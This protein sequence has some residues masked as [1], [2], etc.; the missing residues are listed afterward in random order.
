MD[1]DFSKEAVLGRMLSSAEEL[2][3][4]KY[5]DNLD[6]VVRLLMESFAAE[7]FKVQ[8]NIHASNGR[9]VEHLAEV[10][11]P[12]K[13]T[14]AVPAHGVMHAGCTQITRVVNKNTSY[15]IAGGTV[16]DQKFLFTPIDNV[17]LYHAEVTDVIASH[18]ACSVDSC[19]YKSVITVPKAGSIPQNHMWLGISVSRQ[20]HDI[21]GLSFFIDWP[22]LG[23]KN[24][25][26]RAMSIAKWTVSGTIQLQMYKGL[27][28]VV[29]DRDKTENS[30]E[31]PEVHELVVNDIKNSYQNQFFT[32][33]NSSLKLQENTQKYPTVFEN[34]FSEQ[35]LTQFFTE[36]KLWI[37]IELP[38]YL[39][40][41]ILNHMLV[42]TNAFPIINR[43]LKQATTNSYAIPLVCESTERIVSVKEVYGTVNGAYKPIEL[44][45]AQHSSNT[46]TFKKA[47]LERFDLRDAYELVKYLEL[48]LKNEVQAFV[49][50]NNKEDSQELTR[51][52]NEV[53]SKTKKVSNSEY[54]ALQ[55]VMLEKEIPDEVVTA[56]FWVTRCEEANQIRMG[57]LSQDVS[58]SS[59]VGC[60]LLTHTIGG[61]D[62]QSETERIRAYQY[63]LLTKEQIVSAQDIKS[64]IHYQLGDQVVKV[65]VKSG[66]VIG[67]GS[68][69]GLVRSID[70]YI[71]TVG[72]FQED[73]MQRQVVSDALLQKLHQQSDPSRTYRIF[74][75]E[76]H[77]V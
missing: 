4:I 23:S 15:E 21:D 69:Q 73:A 49:S 25:L 71:G 3:G 66:L 63:A 60:I 46:Y 29:A 53:V 14:A 52:L 32:I 40:A 11:T 37:K 22:N 19:I 27:L 2:W 76:S 39:E 65:D 31:R 77:K 36:D 64:F 72:D 20:L 33:S 44:Q 17:R 8:Q 7:I 6:P 30:F 47:G 9:L 61:K 62:S 42:N 74:W 50:L 12:T 48:L 58:D 24:D 18:N 70:V 38:I 13:L 45:E 56:E 34:Y 5:N 16:K 57:T 54:K 43:E 26:Y 75:N 51:A 1:F 67:H 41:E 68:K 28:Y 10:L 35:Q 59:Q 55:Y